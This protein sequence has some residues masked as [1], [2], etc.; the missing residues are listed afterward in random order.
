MGTSRKHRED[1]RYQRMR[2][3]VIL[4]CLRMD[5][6]HYKRRIDRI[7]QDAKLS[8]EICTRLEHGLKHVQAVT[9]ET[10]DETVFRILHPSSG[11]GTE[12]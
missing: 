11:E 12:S 2:I 5:V 9:C 1:E 3:A 6:D 7:L 10:L 4:H 8:W